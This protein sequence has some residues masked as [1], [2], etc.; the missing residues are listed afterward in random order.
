MVLALLA[1]CPLIYTL[2][3][4]GYRSKRLLI[5]L[6]PWQDPSGAGYQ[7]IQSL[8]ALGSGGI[9]GKGLGASRQNS[10]FFPKARMTS[11]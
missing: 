10:T 8:I 11:Y 5:Y 3:N 4:V 2:L 9:F 6:D 1:S 7:I